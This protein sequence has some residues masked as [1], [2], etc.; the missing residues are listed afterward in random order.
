MVLRRRVRWSFGGGG[1]GGGWRE[2]HAVLVYPKHLPIVVQG[3]HTSAEATVDASADHPEPFVLT[4]SLRQRFQVA[5]HLFKGLAEAF[6]VRFL[7]FGPFFCFGLDLRQDRGE[8]R[9]F[10]FQQSLQF[11]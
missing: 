4:Q 1:T 6:E 5:A 7:L 8:G 2:L 11:L 10:A 9:L 3:Y